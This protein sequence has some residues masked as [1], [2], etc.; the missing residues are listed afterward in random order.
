MKSTMRKLAAVVGGCLSLAGALPPAIAQTYPAKPIRLVIGI[1]P[2]GSMDVVGR[3]AA[4]KLAERMG[5]PWVVENKPG[6]SFQIS[7]DFVAKAPPDGYTLLVA[8][9]GGMAIAP[10]LYS[11]LPYDTVRDF[12]PVAGLARGPYMLLGQKGGPD[13][14]REVIAQ[15][16]ASP[17]VFN[18]AHA[19]DGTGS[20]LVG[21][22]FKF[23]TGADLTPVPFKAVS[24][25]I[26]TMSGGNQ[27]HY[28]WVDP[29]NGLVGVRTGKLK[30]LVVTWKDRSALMPEAPS[31]AEFGYPDFEASGWFGFFAPA[32]TPP[33]IV[34]RLSTETQRAVQAAD[35]RERIIGTANEPWPLSAPDLAAYLK[36]EIAKWGRTVKHTGTKVQ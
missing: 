8:S 29:Q 18:Y 12:A 11:K 17:G 1:A 2:G 36:S 27:V 23:S 19:G 22:M 35:A 13:S 20:H 14:I 5:Q 28:A 31:M 34:T 33:D 32:A 6:A 7:L 15:S 21:E 4:A 26:P 3:I 9:S 16:K 24:N 30:V 10:A 25:I